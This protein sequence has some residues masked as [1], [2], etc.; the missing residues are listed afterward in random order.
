MAMNP[1]GLR[2]EIIAIL[3]LA[4][5]SPAQDVQIKAFWLDLSTVIIDHLKNNA[6]LKN[7][8]LDDSTITGT[9]TGSTVAGTVTSGIVS[10]QIE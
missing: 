10:G 1:S 5:I 6:E 2:D 3:D 4:G 9:V 7:A 8:S